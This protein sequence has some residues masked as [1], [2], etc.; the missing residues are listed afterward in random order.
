MAVHALL[1]LAVWCRCIHRLVVCAVSDPIEELTREFDD[2]FE[3]GDEEDELTIITRYLR[4]AR[5]LGLEEAAATLDPNGKRTGTA[6][7]QCSY[8]HMQIRALIESENADGR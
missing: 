6:Q 5:V 7:C 1:V 4:R 2:A 3:T 8:G